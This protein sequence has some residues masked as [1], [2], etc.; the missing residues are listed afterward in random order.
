MRTVLIADD[1]YSNY[2]YLTELLDDIDAV[3]IYASNGQE[4][5]DLCMSNQSVDLVFMDIRMPIM[6][7]YMAAKLIKDL[8]PDLPIIAQTAYAL[9][10]N[11]KEYV[12]DFDAYMIKP[13]SKS[14]FR[15]TLS[16][17]ISEI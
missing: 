14:T 17:F 8:R 6:N 5:L 7:G 11:N 2:L 3:I 9:D 13:I 16:K 12:H 1:E 4:A 10:K 15:Q